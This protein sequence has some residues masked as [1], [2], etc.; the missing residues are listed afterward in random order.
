MRGVPPILALVSPL[1]RRLFLTTLLAW[2]VALAAVTA[3]QLEWETVPQSAQEELTCGDVYLR[4]KAQQQ[5]DEREVRR[6]MEESGYDRALAESL[7][8]RRPIDFH[9]VF[10]DEGLAPSS[11]IVREQRDA[12]VIRNFDWPV[13][14]WVFATAIPAGIWTV[15]VALRLIWRKP[16]ESEQ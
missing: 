9:W 12:S 1:T 11:T 7:L 4:L 15:G 3:T 5:A 2:V 8:P 16:T 6:M 10:C 14:G 13:R